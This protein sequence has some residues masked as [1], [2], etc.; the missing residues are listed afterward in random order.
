MANFGFA[1]VI[2]THVVCIPCFSEDI[3]I[4]IYIYLFIF[5]GQKLGNFFEFVCFL[6]ELLLSLLILFAK[7]LISRNW[8][9]K[10]KPWLYHVKE[11]K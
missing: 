5:L 11:L 1:K 3:Y 9:I 8:K 10:K 2:Y 7:Y 6:V 4:Y